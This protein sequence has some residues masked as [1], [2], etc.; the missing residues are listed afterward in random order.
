[1]LFKF[2]N[3]SLYENITQGLE[4]SISYTYRLELFLEYGENRFALSIFAPLSADDCSSDSEL[5]KLMRSSS[6]ESFFF[7]PLSIFVVV[8]RKI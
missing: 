1:M 2:N 6:V 3:L 8:E 7:S 5:S 4:S